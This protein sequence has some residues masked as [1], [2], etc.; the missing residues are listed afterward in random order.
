M[1]FIESLPSPFSKNNKSALLHSD[2]VSKAIS[3]LITKNL[4]IENHEPPF[5]VN[6]LSVSIQSSGKKRLILDLRLDDTFLWKDKIKFEDWNNALKYFHKD[7]F[8]FTFDLKSGYHHVDIFP[9]HYKYLGFSW[10]MNGVVR[11]FT[12]TVLHFGLTSALFSFTKCLR[13][14]LKHWRGKGFAVL[15][16]DDGWGR[17][18]SRDDCEKAAV[19]VKSDLIASG[20]V[21]SK[22]N[23][24]WCP[25]QI[26]DWLGFSWNSLE[27]SLCVTQRQVKD[28][29]SN[30]QHLQEEAS[31]CNCEETCISCR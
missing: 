15:Y 12:F 6:P 10:P 13:P 14:F 22:E 27:G 21:P 17:E 31:S 20:L 3:D 29:K 11:Y 7:D 26:V 19:S 2:F 4:V 28:I 18:S 5:V 1:P 23:S 16:L 24:V 25:T 30:I 9:D 8:M